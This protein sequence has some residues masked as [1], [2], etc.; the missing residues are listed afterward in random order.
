ML[1]TVDVPS[2][3]AVSA[4]PVR[5]PANVVA[6]SVPVFVSVAFALAPILNDNVFVVAPSIVQ[7]EPPQPTLKAAPVIV[8]AKKSPSLSK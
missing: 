6:V 7:V 2:L 8:L 4:F 5:A 3:V 1:P